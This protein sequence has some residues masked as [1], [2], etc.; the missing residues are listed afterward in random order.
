[1]VTTK[2]LQYIHR[3]P[4]KEKQNKAQKEWN[5]NKMEE[6]IAKDQTFNQ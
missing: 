2:V 5:K 1:M 3:E 6:I 4:R